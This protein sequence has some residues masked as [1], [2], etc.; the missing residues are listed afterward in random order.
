[1]EDSNIRNTSEQ[2]APA[3][4]PVVRH[5]QR[6]PNEEFR[7]IC[8]PT[9]QPDPMWD[10]LTVPLRLA[11]ADAMRPDGHGQLPRLAALATEAPWSRQLVGDVE[12]QLRAQV[13]LGRPWINFDPLL[14]VGEPGAGKTWFARRLGAAL[15][16]DS[17]TLEL[18]ST[19]DDRMLSGTAR[20]WSSA[21]PAWPLIVM[22][23]N[24]CANP[25][26]ILD[27]LD[28][29]GGSQRSGHPHRALLAM[30][31][32]ASS[33]AWH[34]QYLLTDCD[35]SHVNWIACANDL[36]PI[37]RPLL[38]RFHV[39]EVP[40]LGADDF[41]ALLTSVIRETAKR[42]E[43]PVTMLPDLPV[44]AVT[45]LRDRFARHPSIRALARDT[46]AL[47]TAALADGHGPRRS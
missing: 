24:H 44:G 43:V 32:R 15:D 40:K 14:L 29:A 31:D 36:S 9:L 3:T 10:R 8:R 42:W 35:L 2:P 16:L 6:W 38:S 22:A 25:L 18:G 30:L 13:A 20:G 33:V 7:V 23:D 34:D 11:G 26:L 45:L 37:P 19:S 47:L 5:R 12:R 21:Q 28:K 39:I 1:M 4:P 41:D 27:E 46:R 17:A